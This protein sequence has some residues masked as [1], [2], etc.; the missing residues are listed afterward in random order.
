MKRQSEAIIAYSDANNYSDAPNLMDAHS[1]KY[2][3]FSPVHGPLNSENI[4]RKR[5]C[6]IKNDRRDFGRVCRAR[7]ELFYRM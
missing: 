3:R 4:H 6:A 7:S 1:I 2:S 5:V